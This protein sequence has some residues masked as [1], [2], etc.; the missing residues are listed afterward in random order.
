[1]TFKSAGEGEAEV[2][3]IMMHIPG[4]LTCSQDLTTAHEGLLI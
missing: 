1:M 4:L 2:E 3:S